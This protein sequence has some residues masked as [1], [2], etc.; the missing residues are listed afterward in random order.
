MRASS[1]PSRLSTLFGR[2]TKTTARRRRP[3][4]DRGPH[5]AIGASERLEERFAL[6]ID[7]FRYPFG[8]SISTASTN[9]AILVMDNGDSGYLRRNA[10]PS[11]SMTYA[12]NS[13]FLNS[14]GNTALNIGELSSTI[15]SL[16]SIFVTAGSRSTTGSGTFGAPSL[17][18][19]VTFPSVANPGGFG[20]IPGT[21][22]GFVT[23]TDSTG[24]AASA[25][26]L[27]APAFGGELRVQR[28]SGTGALPLSVSDG[29]TSSF[30]DLFTGQVT[31]NFAAAPKSL[32]LTSI[33]WGVFQ[34]GGSPVS[35]TLSPGLTPAQRFLVDLSG[36]PESSITLDSP[37]DA[38]RGSAS[39]APSGDGFFA[40][41]GGV[42]TFGQVVLRATNVTTNANVKTATLFQTTVQ[43]A[44]VNRPIAAQTHSIILDGSTGRPASLV[45]ADQGAL[46]NSLTAPATSPAGLLSLTANQADVTFAGVVNA[47]TQ[48]YLFNSPASDPRGYT[49]TT[50]SPASGVQTGL[51]AGGTIVATLANSAGGDVD[52]ETDIDTLRFTSASTPGNPVLPY[53]VRVRDADDLLIDAVPAS[54]R[55]ISLEAQGTLTLNAAIQTTGDLS[56]VGRNKLTISAPISAAA[57]SVLLQADAISTTG[58]VTSG[59]MRR[60]S[61]ESTGATGD[62]QVG[63]LVRAGGTVRTPV[64]AA[65]NANVAL[66][67][68]QT[69]DGVALVVGDR[70]LVKNQTTA[71][72]NG[73]YVVAAGAWTR[74]ADAATSSQFDPGFVV[75]VLSGTQ[76]G[77]WAFANSLA[78][79]LNQT[80]LYFFPAT[81]TQTYLPV[82]AAST[83]SITLSGLQTIDGVALVAGDRFLVK[84][85]SNQRQNGIY[86]VATGAWERASDANTS[87]DLRAGSYVFVTSGTNNGTRGFMLDND[88]VQVGITPLTFSAF[89]VQANRTNPFTPANVLGSVVAA[90]TANIALQGLPVIDGI[91]VAAG[92]RVLVKNQVDPSANG[93]YLAAAGAWNRAPGANTSAG[94]A[95]GT[96]VSVTGGITNAGTSWI[97]DD[98][99]AALA[100]VRV[101]DSSV[102]G[103]ASTAAL[104]PGM[105]VTGPG[106]QTGTTISQILGPTSIRLSFAATIDDPTA[107]LSF[108]SISP[109]AVGTEPIF[110]LASGGLLT[111]TAGRSITS[112][113][114]ITSRLQGGIAL[115]S[116]GRPATGAASAASSL[117]ANANVGRLF[118]GAP[119][120][121]TVSNT[122]SVDVFDARTTVGGNLAIT[123]G[124]T[125]AAFSLLTTGAAAAVTLGTTSG[126]LVAATIVGAGGNV[127]LTTT[128]GD[129]F[130][131]RLG[132]STANV[133]ARNGTVSVTANRT[134]GSPGG[135]IRVDG[136]VF[137][138]GTNN[139]VVL[140]TNDGQ[141]TFTAAATVGAADQLRISTPG[142]T[143]IVDPA[144]LGKI[145]AG[146][147]SLEAPFGASQSYP[148]ALGT[149]QVLAVNRTD[150]GDISITSAAT[151]TIEG[152]RTTS[153]SITFSAPDVTVA[154]SISPGGATSSITLTATAGDL[155]V[156]APLDSPNGISLQ[157]PT[158]RI[159]D[160]TG[161]ST[162][163]ITAAQTLVVR[164]AS[165]A[166]LL[167]KVATI[168][169]EL[170]AVDAALTVT[171]SDG[172]VLQSLK[173]L[174]GG[175]ADITV[176]SPA[177]GGSAT[178]T[179]ADVGATGTLRIVAQE[180]ILSTIDG[181]ADLRGDRAEL[182]AT[183]GRIEIE[184]AL[185]ALVV[186]AQQKN[187]SIK[188]TDLGAGATPLLLESVAGGS[189]ADVRVKAQRSLDA[190]FVQT[191]GT[192]S[193]QTLGTG[194]DIIVGLIDAVGNTVSLAAANAIREQAP[195]DPEA[196]VIATTVSLSTGTGGI[197]VHLDADAVSA[198]AAPTATVGIR[199]DGN[200][201]IGDG[202][203]GIVGGVVTLTLGGTLAQTKSITASRLVVG[204]TTAGGGVGTTLQNASNAIGTIAITGGTNAV[205]LVNATAV[206]IDGVS[207]TAVS[208]QAGGVVSQA[209]TPTARITAAAL[210][211]TATG[212]VTLDN[213]ANAVTAI[214]G[215]TTVGTFAYV[216]ADG[217]SVVTPGISAGV[218]GPGNGD[219][220]LTATTGDLVVGGSLTALADRIKLS[221]PA[222]TITQTAG[223]I[224]ADVLEWTARSRP[225]LPNLAVSVFG[226]N[227]TGPGPLQIGGSGQPITVASASTADGDI[228]IVGSD[229]VI[230]GPVQVGGSGRSV[231]VSASGLLRFQNTGRIINADTA[232]S[233]ALGVGTTIGATNTATQTTV[234][235]AGT[236]LVSSGA[237]ANLKTDIGSL[238]AT[239]AAGGLTITDVGAF[240][241]VAINAAG[242]PVSLAAST[243]ITQGGAIVAN[244]LTATS[245]TGGVILTAANDVTSVGGSTGTGDFRFTDAN[246]FTA[247]VIT[248]GTTAAGDGSI[249]LTASTGNLVLA[250]NLTAIADTVTLRAPAG[251]ITQSAGVIT[252]DTLI[253]QAQSAS[254]SSGNQVDSVGIN[255]TSIGSVRIPQIG[256]SAGTL[257]IAEVTTV[258][259]NIEIVGDDVRISGLVQAGGA[260][261][262]VVIT[263][264]TGG[265]TFIQNGRVVA[266][267]DVTLTAATGIASSTSAPLVNVTTPA[268]L[269]ATGG[270]GG[271]D[272]DTAVGSVSVSAAGDI[273]LTEADAVTLTSV[274]AAAGNVTVSAGGAITATSVSASG[275]S[276]NLS[277]STG[278]V[279]VGT[280]VA[281]VATGIVTVNAAGSIVDGDVGTDLAGFSAVLTAGGAISLDLAVGTVVATAGGVIDLSDVDA[282]VLA[283]IVSQSGSVFVSAGGAITA[284]AVTAAAG[285][286]A[287]LSTAGDIGIGAVAANVPAGGVTVDAAGSIVG[288]GAG[289]DLTSAIATLTARTGSIG[290]DLA[291]GG[292]TASAPGGITLT[293]TDGIT[294]TSVVSTG[295]SVGV[296]TAA[297]GIAV[298]QVSANAV[299]G[300]V[301]LNAAGGITDTDGDLDISAASALLIA[302]TGGIS[303]DLAV[304]SV[305]A[306]APGSIDLADVD[307]V[308]LTSVVSTAGN[309]VITAGGSLVASSV[310]ATVGSVSL[311]T[312]AGDVAVGSVTAR[313]AT[314]SAAGSITDGDASVDLTATSATLAAG[315]GSIDLDLAVATVGGSAAGAVT[316]SNSGSVTLANL[317]STAG[318]IV[319]VVTAGSI[320]IAG[321]SANATSGVVRLESSTGTVT[322]PGGAVTAN[323]LQVVAPA[324]PAVDLSNAGNSVSTL[325]TSIGSAT[326]SMANAGALSIVAD[327]GLAIGRVV[328]QGNVAVSTP[329]NLRVGPPTIPFPVLQSTTQ[330]DL[331]GV[332]GTVSLVNGGRLV[333]PSVLLNS[334]NPVID[335]GG[336]VTTTTSLN[337]AVDS[338]NQLT[339]VGG[340][341]YQIAVGANLTL[342]RPLVFD[343]PVALTGAGF[344]LSGSTNVTDGVVLNAGASG[345]RVTNLAF[346]GFS[347]TAMRLISATG[348]TIGGISVSNERVSG[349]GLWI[350]GTS[351]GTTVQG[352]RFTNNDVA[353]RLGESRT[354]GATGAIVGGLAPA[355]RNTVAGARRAGVVATGFCTGTQVIGT[356]FTASP[357]TRVPFDVRSSRGLRISGTT[358]ERAQTSRVAVPAAAVR[359]VSR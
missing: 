229:V 164:A 121:I 111:V 69:V 317:R 338:I 52:L 258:D 192:V 4:V 298:T 221:A 11:P 71:S 223:T 172:V 212:A 124:G 82:R 88:A 240:S 336:T 41:F 346:A 232:G 155:N 348:V 3:A 180:S 93:V 358:V 196:D 53:T 353:I 114:S 272:L 101:G 49:W 165:Q 214:T 119:A 175:V 351:T 40:G 29:A 113:S 100:A 65:T 27:A 285:N 287:L 125:L 66:S 132:T 91:Q 169:A 304:G 260:A 23:L 98:T 122:G 334:T 97:V 234:T 323:T 252:A 310:V 67:G 319:V 248:A 36:V 261:G 152:A 337:Q 83:G 263:A 64:R 7:F 73:I 228:T 349:N 6:A 294:L 174:A 190:N 210:T 307:A 145:T 274:S 43:N 19:S 134:P 78:P 216:D 279:T 86:V 25:E 166:T 225:D 313:T 133:T 123:A 230:D 318:D 343:R 315:T 249:E 139:D 173:L 306:T 299:S 203:V 182:T 151:L 324:A 126:D 245:T 350:S 167:T 311:T 177:V 13:Q 247:S 293:D 244:A 46:A 288:T 30:I 8:T 179:L 45:V 163:L 22:R 184:T 268:V 178:V 213:V 48:S 85:Q 284:T 77:N 80:A 327:A 57:G 191:T 94:L 181:T 204:S 76:L 257:R 345:S 95:R 227:L 89:T 194:S 195:A 200:L 149:Y 329:G 140:S 300:S 207:G 55:P 326:L 347:G 34:G 159:G 235:A 295:G 340:A 282:V 20:I 218:S 18:T 187:Q 58:L 273:V 305:V 108:T 278:D 199:N 17:S 109:V 251:V 110:F 26:L 193:L 339:P 9:Y 135:N 116:A 51:L 280:V 127:S 84:D 102:T 183:T 59:A 176:G 79:T 320:A 112:G 129:V 161:G 33:D 35:F 60:V 291:V 68:A 39:A 2:R 316:V 157:A 54:G 72:Q 262:T 322:Q 142:Q 96:T 335:V 42:T 330:L 137:A 206:Q 270:S 283:G 309:L 246:A 63:S 253:W 156:D 344:T 92:D 138:E 224:T 197:D 136:R 238:V 269:R 267:G 289:V 61:L 220:S 10:T 74:A 264:A 222:G 90:T 215:S 141:V 321:I 21:F 16:D 128:A 297:G 62:V 188:I 118:A 144:A 14:G 81:A 266:A 254:F 162:P 354:T 308:T 255:V 302:G 271:I 359:L 256:T 105:L 275:G 217:F 5:I 205:S 211:V 208:L 292:V 148:A 44:F 209:A 332:T 28:I 131:T 107:S 237:A 130:V 331:R 328:A 226:L 250:G 153:G 259:G 243:G 239:V 12:N 236:L 146:R 341:I 31:L 312:S 104:V 303:A 276:V 160:S 170:S 198:V 70:V 24:A 286:V 37:L 277:T 75:S 201:S 120:G 325:Q 219:I 56:L 202:A 171:E 15:G 32:T 241:V 357:R 265:I 281:G 186:S 352:S 355:E 185:N 314:V 342:S 87:A 296:T 50:M 356:T 99:V 117:S 150:P 242:Q 103:L 168:D 158:G 115:M 1:L 301:A 147:L 106:I 38:S 47:T 290:L 189:Q 233:V 143:P 154:G 333:A 231:S